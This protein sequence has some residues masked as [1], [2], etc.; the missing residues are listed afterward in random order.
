MAVTPAITKPCGYVLC[1]I[2]NDLA[3]LKSFAPKAKKA[4]QWAAFLS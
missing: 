4:A 1:N 2:I 3:G